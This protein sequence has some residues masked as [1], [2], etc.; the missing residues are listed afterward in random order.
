MQYILPAVIAAV[1]IFAIKS[2]TDAYSAFVEGAEDG[3][4]IV[5]KIMPPLLA[6][7]SASQMLRA[8]GA[9]DKIG[10]AHV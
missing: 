3:L 4:K 7:L 5:V 6:V 10:R 9:F 1:I 2:R 8:S